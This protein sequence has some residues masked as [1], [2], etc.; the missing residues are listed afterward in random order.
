MRRKDCPNV[1]GYQ[2][3][4]GRWML[5]L[6]DPFSPRWLPVDAVTLAELLDVS[7]RTGVRLCQQPGRLRPCEVSWLQVQL[8]GM[9]PDQAFLRLGMFFQGGMMYSHDLPGVAFSPGDLAAWQVQRRAYSELTG[10]LAA[11]RERIA[12]LERVLNPEP[13]PAPPANVIRFPSR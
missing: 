10:L 11:A 5:R 12:E 2:T 4:A 7:P 9:V 8:F 3:D 13:E 6:P 1:T